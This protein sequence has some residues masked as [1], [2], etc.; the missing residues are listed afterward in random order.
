MGSE[1]EP[2]IIHMSITKQANDLMQEMLDKE[3]KP[4]SN[5]RWNKIMLAA[6]K[7]FPVNPPKK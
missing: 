4:I 2:L 5:K 1:E 7:K 3:P 6:E